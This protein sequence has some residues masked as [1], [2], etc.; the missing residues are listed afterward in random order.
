MQLLTSTQNNST[1]L[2]KLINEKITD[3]MDLL[4]IK[5][6]KNLLDEL[7]DLILASPP[8]FQRIIKTEFDLNCACDTFSSQKTDFAILF[9]I[10]YKTIDLFKVYFAQQNSAPEIF[11]TL[12][13]YL[14]KVADIDFL[15]ICDKEFPA[16]REALM[17]QID[18]MTHN[19]PSVSI[20]NA[21]FCKLTQTITNDKDTQLLLTDLYKYLHKKIKPNSLFELC[22]WVVKKNE[23]PLSQNKLPKETIDIINQLKIV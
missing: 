16:L 3:G 2:L 4:T 9:S 8:I 15:T 14:I 17:Q 5:L 20:K 23:A 21:F 1:N 11:A 18:D 12:A 22:L 13:F 7:A 10:Y 6:E 19:Y